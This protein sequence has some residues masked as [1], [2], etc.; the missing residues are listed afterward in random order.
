MPVGSKPPSPTAIGPRT[1]NARTWFRQGIGSRQC[2]SC[3]PRHAGP[4][5]AAHRPAV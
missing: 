3:T 2:W 5:G 1:P 4:A